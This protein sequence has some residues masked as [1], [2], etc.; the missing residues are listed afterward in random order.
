M[1]TIVQWIPS[2]E[3]ATGSDFIALLRALG[4]NGGHHRQIGHVTNLFHFKLGN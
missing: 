3:R 1:A 4:K 2:I